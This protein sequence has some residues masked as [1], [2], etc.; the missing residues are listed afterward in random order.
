MPP[1][2][3]HICEKIGEIA[4]L[5][6]NIENIMQKL[7]EIKEQLKQFRDNFDD[8]T[9]KYEQEKTSL[10]KEFTEFSNK[11]FAGK[12]TEKI[13]IFIWSVIWTALIWAIMSLILINR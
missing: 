13:I 11:N 8:F 12:W 1:K 4:T 10:T 7:W 9:K 5:E 2:K 3:T 6:T